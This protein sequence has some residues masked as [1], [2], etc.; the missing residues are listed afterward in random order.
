MPRNS[1]QL[2]DAVRSHLSAEL[3]PHLGAA[4]RRFTATLAAEATPPQGLSPAW[5]WI[6][7]G[8]AAAAGVALAG[9]LWLNLPNSSPPPPQVADNDGPSAV[10]RPVPEAAA[11]PV[12]LDERWQSRDLGTYVDADGR[13]VRAIG[14]RQWRAMR[15]R[16]ED[17]SDVRIE[18]PQNYLVLVDA[19]VR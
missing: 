4:R 18:V 3:D 1:D 6:G 11:T 13:P 19:P 16:N 2:E 8:L 5:R 17:G 12:R 9:G 10:M 14:R 7:G 15:Y